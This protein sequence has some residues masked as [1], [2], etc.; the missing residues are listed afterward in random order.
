M[1]T[2]TLKIRNRLVFALA[3]SAALGVF[4]TPIAS[5]QSSEEVQQL[6]A[7]MQQMQKNM[8]EMQKKIAELEREKAAAPAP[9][10]AV[11]KTPASS[12]TL[13]KVAA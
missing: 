1:K 4:T 13:E 9:A 12:P 11:G 6:K 8:E 5:A 2:T 7:A 10:P 3:A